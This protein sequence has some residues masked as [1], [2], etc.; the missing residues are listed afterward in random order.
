MIWPWLHF[1]VRVL[2][3]FFPLQV[4]KEILIFWESLFGNNAE[5]LRR[6]SVWFV[7]PYQCI[8]TAWKN[9]P[10]RHKYGTKNYKMDNR[11]GKTNS[12]GRCMGQRNWK[13]NPGFLALRRKKEQDDR[14]TMHSLLGGVG[15]SAFWCWKPPK[16]KL[17]GQEISTSGGKIPGGY[18]R[19]M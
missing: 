9:Y 13:K 4:F 1:F 10:I 7:Y 6:G 15:H 18:T 12:P 3:R 5:Q 19:G 11:H 2:V 16:I 14:S 17:R 8:Q